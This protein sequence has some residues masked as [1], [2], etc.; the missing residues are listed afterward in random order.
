MNGKAQIRENWDRAWPDGRISG[1]ISV[2]FAVRVDKADPESEIVFDLLDPMVED[3]TACEV[4]PATT[5]VMAGENV[6][7]TSVPGWGPQNFEVKRNPATV[8]EVREESE[9]HCGNGESDEQ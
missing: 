2:V 9:Q 6:V 7:P 1:Q 3:E 4:G 8:E 5:A